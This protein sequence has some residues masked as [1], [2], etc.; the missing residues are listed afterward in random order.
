M[1]RSF[2]ALACRVPR[3]FLK[4]QQ[5]KSIRPALE[6][7]SIAGDRCSSCAVSVVFS[8]KSVAKL[9]IA[10]LATTPYRRASLPGL[11]AR[12]ALSN[13]LQAPPRHPIELVWEQLS[14]SESRHDCVQLENHRGRGGHVACRE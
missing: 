1:P 9:D 11:D 5:K 4:N 7:S 14:P 6:L 3:K 10:R 12:R 8:V 13:L 2:Q